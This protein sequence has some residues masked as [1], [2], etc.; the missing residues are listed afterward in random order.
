MRRN[1]LSSYRYLGFEYL[2]L[3]VSWRVRPFGEVVAVAHPN[4]QALNR[5]TR[6]A[7]YLLPLSKLNRTLICRTRSPSSR[8]CATIPGRLGLFEA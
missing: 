7:D 5:V 8:S 3:D 6:F 1:R 4:I 2:D